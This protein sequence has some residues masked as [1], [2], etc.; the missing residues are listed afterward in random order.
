MFP[1]A[2]RRVIFQ[3]HSGPLRLNCDV[4]DQVSMRF[5]HHG[6]MEQHRFCR[7]LA[8]GDRHIQPVYGQ[9][10]RFRMMLN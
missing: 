1:L 6:N 9:S 3:L 7:D 8:Q 2:S 10:L 5:T 4:L